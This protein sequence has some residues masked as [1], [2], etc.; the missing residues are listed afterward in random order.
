MQLG[1][2]H[3][4]AFAENILVKSFT[5]TNLKEIVIEQMLITD[6]T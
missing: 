3:R 4:G 5:Q 2:D 1:E 6:P